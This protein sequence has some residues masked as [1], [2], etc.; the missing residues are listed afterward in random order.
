MI[1]DLKLVEIELFSYCNR[2]CEWCPNSIIDRFTNNYI[3][4]KN[5]LNKIIIEL[6][7]NNYSGAIS[8]SRY[9]EPMSHIDLLKDRIDFIKNYLPNVKLISNTNGDFISEENL[10]QLYID[11]LTIMDYD[12][13]GL[14]QCINKLKNAN[15]HIREIKYPYIYGKFDDI[16]ILYFVDW[17]KFAK[18]SNRGGILNEY[19]KNNRTFK[20]EKPKRFI[21][22]NYDGTVSPCAEIRNDININ[23]GYILGS[24]FDNSIEE[25][26]LKEKTIKFLNDCESAI[27]DFNSPCY[28]CDHGIGRYCKE[29]GN[30]IRY[31]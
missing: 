31:E 23:K 2:K 18:I 21:G 24:L 27:F 14:Q 16:E 11:E 6:S 7:H 20:C 12:C 13:I 25:I 8:F 15:V 28:M 19:S 10:K 26:L 9:N 30:G 17:I 3:L 1:K 5:I 29:S 22:I 4:N